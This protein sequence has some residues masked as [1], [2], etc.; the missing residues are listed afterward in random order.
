[1]KAT[2]YVL[3]DDRGVL[4]LGGAD[5]RD[6]LQGLVSNDLRLL[7]PE[8]A[9]YA[10]LLTPQG[11]YLFDFIAFEQG[12]AILLDV[13]AAR[14]QELLRRLVMYRLR[15]KVTIEDRSAD[16]R[17]LVVVGM[18]EEAERGRA[19][20]WEGGV[21]AVDP[22][23]A[24]LGGRAIVPLSRLA[25]LPLEPMPRRV[26]DELRLSLGVPESSTDLVVQKSL[27]LESNFVELAGVSF[28]KGCYVGQELTA[29][30]KYRALVRKRLLP[31]VVEGPLP[32][33]GT[34]LMLAGREAGEMR[35][36]LGQR[37]MALVRLEALAG[38]MPVLQAG[39][40]RLRPA[41]PEWLGPPPGT[42]A[43]SEG[44]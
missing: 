1:M 35:S 21:V 9:V 14:C 17:V 25:G 37:G 5:A 38:G 15:A 12:D 34:P 16:L 4:A 20:S 10:A 18:Q 3:L 6:F 41:W 44:A 13:E 19:S 23:V 36:G 43:S 11:K 27:L 40:S 30:T 22:R 29:R 2:G 26:Y 42:E 39:D 8:R 31:V 32:E 33:P 28:D 7:S 24:E